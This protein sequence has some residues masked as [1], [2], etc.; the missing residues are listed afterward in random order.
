MLGVWWQ[1]GKPDEDD[2][3]DDE[4]ETEQ[5]KLEREARELSSQ[6]KKAERAEALACDKEERDKA[7]RY[8]TRIAEGHYLKQLK[9]VTLVQTKK[10]KKSMKMETNQKC[11]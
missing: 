9:A 2:D 10:R 11:G 3:D 1:Q 8:S 5:D 7:K 4:D 6:L